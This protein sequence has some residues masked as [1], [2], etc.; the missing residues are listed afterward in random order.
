MS[1]LRY[2]THAE[3]HIDP[4]VPVPSWSLSERGRARVM[5]ATAQ[6]WLASIGEV[7]SSG[8]TKALETA[9][10]LASACGGLAVSV[11][12]DTGETD[13]SATGFVTPAEH[14]RLATA[15]FA[16]PDTSA[17]GW[18]TATAA[19]ARIVAA[20]GPHL[21]E[22]A[23]DRPHDTLVVGHGG[24]GTLLLCH[25]AG[26]PI[27]QRHDQPTQGHYWTLDQATGRVEHRWRA[28]DDLETP[29]S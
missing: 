23:D 11:A 10:L 16:H 1:L 14:D 22:S 6:P 26:L 17:D 27:E 12:A 3:V 9:E 19:Q 21:T 8:E 13:R 29:P 15:F 20:L 25:L 28:I 24:V 4:D 2:V 18:E 7:I 5:A